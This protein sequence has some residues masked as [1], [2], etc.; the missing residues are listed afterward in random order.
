[1]SRD[2]GPAGS[3]C[4]SA[5]TGRSPD[6][7]GGRPAPTGW[8]PAPGG[9][10]AVHPDA[11]D[12]SAARAGPGVTRSTARRPP[13]AA[14]KP[15][16]MRTILASIGLVLGTV[17]LLLLIREVQRVLVWIVIAGFFAVALYPVVN[18]I[19]RHALRR[20]RSAGHRR[21]HR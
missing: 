21:R 6:P 19:E 17:L 9:V 14:R 11:A 12:T 18:W 20:G 5:A 7:G 1:M 3:P 4:G 16:P 10:P 2:F 13:G 8:P 15:I